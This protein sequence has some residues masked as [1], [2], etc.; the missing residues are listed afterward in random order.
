MPRSLIAL[1]GPAAT[2]RPPTPDRS[3]CVSTRL[4]THRDHDGP[5]GQDEDDAQELAMNIQYRPEGLPEAHGLYDPR[6]IAYMQLTDSLKPAMTPGFGLLLD[7]YA[8]LFADG[9]TNWSAWGA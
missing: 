1:P 6:K 9:L 7:G 4:T 5:G 3:S 8:H 2:P